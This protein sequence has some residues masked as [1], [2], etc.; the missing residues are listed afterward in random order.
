MRRGSLEAMQALQHVE[1]GAQRREDESPTQDTLSRSLGSVRIQFESSVGRDY[2][3]GICYCIADEPVNCGR[4][5]GCAALYCSSCLSMALHTKRQC[6]TCS[7]PIPGNPIKNMPMKNLILAKTVFCLHN[8][9]KDAPAAGVAGAVA[10]D[11]AAAAA[12]AAGA[13]T[14]GGKKRKAAA[15]DPAVCEWRGKYSE[16]AT[17][18]GKDCPGVEVGCANAGCSAK[19]LRCRLEE[20]GAECDF[21]R[22]PCEHCGEQVLRSA[23]ANHIEEDCQRAPVECDC[24]KSFPRAA[25]AAHEASCPEVY[26]PCEYADLGCEEEVKRKDLPQH[27]DSAAKAHNS[28]LLRKVLGLQSQVDALR[29]LTLTWKVEGMA[30]KMLAARDVEKYFY[31]SNF[32]VPELGGGVS[33]MFLKIK[34]TVTKLGLYFYKRSKASG[35]S[36][37]CDVDISGWQLTLSGAGAQAQ[38]TEKMNQGAK[39]KVGRG[40]GWDFAEGVT[41]FIANDAITITA[42]V[43]VNGQ[44]APLALTTASL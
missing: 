14:R 5:E 12:A 3:C 36:S 20:H 4:H 40:R 34:M 41:P 44:A 9:S 22:E 43:K 31:S 25:F 2:E 6:P 24:G 13:G 17:H 11:G 18:L 8:K 42:K 27:M 32:D 19:V 15:L 10:A 33:K 35:S 29:T 37:D 16:L 23:M 21:R 26:C 39:S 28:L 7:H 38:K 30:A 1:A